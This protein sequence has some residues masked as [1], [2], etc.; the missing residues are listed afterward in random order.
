LA[1]FGRQAPPFGDGERRSD[2]AQSDLDGDVIAT[3]NEQHAKC[4]NVDCL[5]AQV[6]VDELDVEVELAD[7]P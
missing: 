2:A 1:D 3:H 6:V 7:V 5:V 4:G